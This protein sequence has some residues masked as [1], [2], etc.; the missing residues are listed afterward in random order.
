MML[1]VSQKF[2]YILERCNTDVN[3]TF[4]YIRIVLVVP[5]L[6]RYMMEPSH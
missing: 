4:D 5:S 2:V 1:V 6:F 3:N